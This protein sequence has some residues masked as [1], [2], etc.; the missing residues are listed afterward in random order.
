M[1]WLNFHHLRY[2]S[3]VAR[4]GSIARASRVLHVSQPSISTQL[5]LLEQ[6]LGEKLLQK[7]GRGLQLT[8]M[9]RLVQV[10]AEQIFALGRDLVDAVRD[11]PTGQ[12]LRLQVG[13]ADVVEKQLTFRLLRPALALD[14]PVR[15]S[16]RE[17]RP[18]RLVADLATFELDVVIT[19]SAQPLHTRARVFHHALGDSP[20]G[21]FGNAALARR[22]RGQPPAAFAKVPLLLPPPTSSLRREIESWAGRHGVELSVLGEFE[23]SALAKT[24][25]A[26]GQ[27]LMFAP[28]VLA[29]D[30]RRNHGLHQAGELDGV[31]TGY[32]ALTVERKVRHP[33][34]A[35][36]LDGARRDLFA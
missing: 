26:N 15:L 27:G 3:T 1:D 23:D 29:D 33:G 34:V 30:F 8:E 28:A 12:P 7:H 32:S 17:D 36:I 31:R 2:F 25:A 5:R 4:E 16:V 35:A 20:V 19:D 21:V 24:F 13:V 18:D 6:S 11:R 9:G 14:V 22:V 10:Y